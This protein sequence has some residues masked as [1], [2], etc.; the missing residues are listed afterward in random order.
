VAVAL[1]HCDFDVED[2][3]SLE[4]YLKFLAEKEHVFKE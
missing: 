2:H 4:E 3:E 1:T